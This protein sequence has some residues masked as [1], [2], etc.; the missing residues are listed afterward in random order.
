MT[1]IEGLSGFATSRGGAEITAEVNEA[2]FNIIEKCR[3]FFDVNAPAFAAPGVLNR[4]C[5]EGIIIDYEQI[6]AQANKVAER[7]EENELET[8]AWRPFDPVAVFWYAVAHE[9]AHVLQARH[10]QWRVMMSDPLTYEAGADFLAGVCLGWWSQKVDLNFLAAVDVAYE[11]GL[12]SL[13]A[14]VHPTRDQRREAVAAGI[15]QGANAVSCL[16]GDLAKVKREKLFDRST[17][18]AGT[19]LTLRKNTDG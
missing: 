13:D 6:L 19:F 14:G 4:A 5:P 15:G 2:A 9:Y 3:Q 16:D 18:L 12:E 1:T 10:V 8:G 7:N 11:V 17:E